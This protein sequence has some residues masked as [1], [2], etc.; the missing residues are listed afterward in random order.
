LQIAHSNAKCE[1][2]ILF[3]VAYDPFVVADT[4]L[5]LTW[6]SHLYDI[7]LQSTRRIRL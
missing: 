1:S 7:K 5:I 6:C 2:D 3:Q 4:T